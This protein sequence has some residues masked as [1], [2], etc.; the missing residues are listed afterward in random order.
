MVRDESNIMKIGRAAIF[1]SLAASSAG[2]NT[3]YPDPA[4]PYLQRTD[5]I[6]LGAGNAQNVN[7]AT[8][9]IDPWPPYAGNRSIPG[10][11]TRM[12]GAVE[13]YQIGGQPQGSG[14]A[15]NAAG[16]APQSAGTGAPALTPL[17]PITPGAS[18]D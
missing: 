1:L 10:N 5:T 12:V 11:G 2:C 3:V 18:S 14:G 17:S 7:A 16:S 13:R 4:I 15:A 8:H 6:T 9:T